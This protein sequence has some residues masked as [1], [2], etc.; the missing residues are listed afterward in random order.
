MAIC[1]FLLVAPATSQA[2]TLSIGPSAGWSVRQISMTP[3]GQPALDLSY[4]FV[5]LGA[6]IQLYGM[7]NAFGLRARL[8][9]SLYQSMTIDE[10]TQASGY[11]Q[12]ALNAE[13]TPVATL[14]MESW[15]LSAGTGIGIVHYFS[16]GFNTERDDVRII[17][18]QQILQIPMFVSVGFNV[19]ETW[20]S[21]E[22]G[23]GLPVWYD[24]EDA[25][26][27]S[28]IKNKAIAIAGLD[29]WLRIS[30]GFSLH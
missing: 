3:H 15:K 8:G 20:I 12:H 7:D 17:S 1:A 29:L 23:A 6:T 4:Q 2:Q 11:A 13:I 9:A 25:F 5:D 26:I 27:Q 30:F 19:K 18:A 10:A 16:G 28:G 14:A 24:T 22:L 21:T